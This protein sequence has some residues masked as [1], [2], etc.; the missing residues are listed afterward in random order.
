MLATAGPVPARP[1]WV[2]TESD[3][4]VGV[5]RQ[6][7]QDKSVMSAQQPVPTSPVVL[8]KEQHPRLL[9]G[10]SARLR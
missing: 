10:I 4:V 7:K 6:Y 3:A 8:D 5:H 9:D 1:G 2:L